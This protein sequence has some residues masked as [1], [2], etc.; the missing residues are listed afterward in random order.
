M[1]HPG[2]LYTR[3]ADPSHSAFLDQM[4]RRQVVD[5][6]VREAREARKEEHISGYK[7]V[8]P[9][10]R[11]VQIDDTPQLV[12]GDVARCA[13]V[14]SDGVAHEGIGVDDTPFVQV[15]E[16]R[17]QHGEIAGGG[18]ELEGFLLREVGLE[19]LDKGLVHLVH[20]EVA[21]SVAMPKEGCEMPPKNPEEFV[22]AFAAIHPHPLPKASEIFLQMIEQALAVTPKSEDEG[23]D[24]FG[25]YG[26]A[27]LLPQVLIGAA[28]TDLQA[29]QFGVYG[30]RFGA[31][32]DEPVLTTVPKRRRAGRLTTELHHRSP[33]TE[34]RHNRAFARLTLCTPFEVKEQLQRFFFHRFVA[35]KVEP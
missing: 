31:F 34:A 25:G 28:D 26:L 22:P 3:L 9:Q 18:V 7:L 5:V 17:R 27:F 24:L 14:P 23:L 20:G 6:R 33:H 19:L 11:V 12:L 2:R 8:T 13:D 15:F 16:E 1:A 4:F 21:H 30:H 10:L 29:V 35:Y 32:P